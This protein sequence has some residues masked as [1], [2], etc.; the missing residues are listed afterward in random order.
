MTTELDR[1]AVLFD[2]YS[3]LVNAGSIPGT[4][5]EVKRTR[6]R[7]AKWGPAIRSHSVPCGSTAG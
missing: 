2:R 1:Q 7:T 6:V 4:T 5:A 3:H